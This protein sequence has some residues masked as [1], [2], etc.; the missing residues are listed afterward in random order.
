MAV[1]Y[2]QFIIEYPEFAEIPQ[3]MVE[4]NLLQ[5]DA[6]T[7]GMGTYHDMYVY[8]VTG[9]HL[10]ESVM[11]MPMSPETAENNNYR[12]KAERILQLCYRRMTISGGGL[13]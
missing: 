4:P 12:I 10:N 11:G 8:A 13:T 3:T 1:T 7:S 5:Y 9:Q 6:A 2:A